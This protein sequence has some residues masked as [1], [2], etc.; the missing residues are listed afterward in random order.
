MTFRRRLSSK[1]R[2]QLYESEAAKARDEE[3]GD[4]PICR[5]CGVA[6]LPGQKWN[7]NHE[8]HK[9]LWL[10]G[11]VDGISHA[12]CNRDNARLYA[13]PLW[14]KSERV[15]K[16]F[17]DITRSRSPMPGGREDRIKKKINREVVLRSPS[18]KQEL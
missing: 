14:A 1:Q 7:E 2:E 4:F 6:V 9:P 3:Q 16:R 11:K 13:V 17:L 18:A 12:R 15:R 5:L 10:G 8:G